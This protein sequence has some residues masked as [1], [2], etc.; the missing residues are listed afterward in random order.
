MG[1]FSAFALKP[2]Q[3]A[4][5]R[6]DQLDGEMRQRIEMLAARL[7]IR[8]SAAV[9]GFGVKAQKNMDAFSSIALNRML[10]SACRADSF[11][12]LC[13]RGKGIFPAAWR[14]RGEP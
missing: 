10:S 5:P 3:G 1:E 14:R 7:D 4:V 9:M 13:R 6:M 11:L 2:E 12:L 8:D